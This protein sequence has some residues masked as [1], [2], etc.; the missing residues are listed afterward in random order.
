MEY[1]K[2]NEIM[3]YN[4]KTKTFSINKGISKE[5]NYNEE[6]LRK[7]VFDIASGLAYLHSIGVVHRDLKPENILVN[8]ENCCKI[9]DFNVSSIL[10]NGEDKFT[11]TEG[12]ICFYAPECCKGKTEPFSGKQVDV[13]ALGI[14]LYIM[15]FRVL[16]FVAKDNNIYE[17][18]NLISSF[19]LKLPESRKVSDG[20]KDLFSKLLEKDPAKRITAQEILKHPW[21][22]GAQIV[23]EEKSSSIFSCCT[24][25]KKNVSDSMKTNKGKSIV[26]NK[27][28][29]NIKGASIIDN[30]KLSVQNQNSSVNSK[31]SSQ[32]QGEMVK[33]K[34][35]NISYKNK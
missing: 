6:E 17:V 24:S 20:L 7:I 35:I 30:K 23:K 10:V 29:N 4:D 33:I 2:K 22:L 34:K 15:T 21:V 27:S 13:W 1:E 11:K 8:E 32:K 19:E 26:D 31:S 3:N 25:N 18:I 14:S 28:N 12:T 5:E 9:S 16:P